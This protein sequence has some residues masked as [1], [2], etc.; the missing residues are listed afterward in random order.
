[1]ESAIKLAKDL[2][3]HNKVVQVSK[4]IFEVED[5]IVTIQK[6]SG[7]R[8]ITCDCINHTRNCNSPAFCYHKAS[9]ILYL[10]NRD[11]LDRLSKL[12]KEYEGYKS[13][14]V[15]VSVDCFLN[16]LNSIREKW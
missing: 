9:V 2:V 10:S 15:P 7:A 13:I 1:M 14:K 11:F 16:D 3:R 8:L 4:N 5:H 12:V 6:K